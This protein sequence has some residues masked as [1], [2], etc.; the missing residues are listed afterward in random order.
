MLTVKKKSKQKAPATDTP[1]SSF[2]RLQDAIKRQ[3]KRNHRLQADLQSL[4]ERYQTEILP[5]ERELGFPIKL[6]IQRLID[7]FPRKALTQWQRREITSWIM[8]EL[9]HL[10]M[11]DTEAAAE[12]AGEYRAMLAD[13]FK[14]TAEEVADIQAQA[15]REME[16]WDEAED[17]AAESL[18]E[19]LQRAIN[20][21]EEKLQAELFE[22]SP[23][24]EQPSSPAAPDPMSAENWIKNLFRRTAKVLHPDREQDPQLRD[25]KHHL[26]SALIDAR[27]RGD[28]MTML[29]LFNDHVAGS[30]ADFSK[31]EYPAVI[32]LL[33]R[34]L[35]NVE[36][37]EHDIVHSSPVHFFLYKNFYSRQK[38]TQERKIKAYQ[39]QILTDYTNRLDLAMALRNVKALQS[40]LRDRV[41]YY[42]E[43]DEWF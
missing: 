43:Y 39:Q 38:P 29:T 9:D 6:L 15:Q 27:D 4:I 40:V 2:S 7:L 32:Q 20:Q 35:A 25:K 10:G 34:Q 16:Q 28:I 11:L 41:G 33:Q 19:L 5:H 37:E 36:G 30:D 22:E 8:E 17:D 14:M 26:M 12:M 21:H 24:P 13:F 3:Q 1:H 42:S 23:A 31:D 18:E